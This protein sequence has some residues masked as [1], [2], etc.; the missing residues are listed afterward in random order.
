MTDSLSDQNDNTATDN[1]QSDLYIRN[2]GNQSIR[3]HSSLAQLRPSGIQR[4]SN[5]VHFAETHREISPLTPFTPSSNDGYDNDDDN[6]KRILER[7]EQDGNGEER[8][9]IPLLTN[10]ES[11]FISL[12]IDNEQDENEEVD[13]ILK[14]PKSKFLDAV[15]NMSNSIM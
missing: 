11:P 3:R 5:R 1:T 15:M 9:G 14:K 10:V 8:E 2:D 13:D 4:T 6:N 12:S 7:F